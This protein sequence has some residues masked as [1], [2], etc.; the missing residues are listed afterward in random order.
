[1]TGLFILSRGGSIENISVAQQW[2]YANDIENTSSADKDACCERE[3]EVRKP[4]ESER[5]FVA[6]REK[7]HRL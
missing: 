7:E 4:G 3:R 6:G 2:I 5:H 1:M